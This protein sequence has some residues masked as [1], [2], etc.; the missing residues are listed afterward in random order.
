[1]NRRKLSDVEEINVTNNFCYR[2]VY[3]NYGIHKMAHRIHRNKRYETS[4]S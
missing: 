1:M 4:N 2:I 3:R